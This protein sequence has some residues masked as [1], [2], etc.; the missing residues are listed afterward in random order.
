[1]SGLYEQQW[2]DAL[3]GAAIQPS[4]GLWDNIANELDGKRGRHNW[5][6]ILLIAATVTVA[7]AFPLTIGNSSLQIRESLEPSIAQNE[8][9]NT[10]SYSGVNEFVPKNE[11]ELTTNKPV[12]NNS[13]DVT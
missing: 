5:V 7:F 2:Q 11:N 6:T 10:S 4:D 12:D 1:M 8:G 3:A 13:Q 9:G